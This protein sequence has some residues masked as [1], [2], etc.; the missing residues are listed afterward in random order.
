MTLAHFFLSCYERVFRLSTLFSHFS[1]LVLY[2]V[3]PRFFGSCETLLSL[4][5]SPPRKALSASPTLHLGLHLFLSWSLLF[6]LH[7]AALTLLILASL[8]SLPSHDLVI[9]T[10]GLVPFSFGE[11]GFG[12]LVNCLLCAAEVF[13][14]CLADPAC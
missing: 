8:D 7:T 10:D 5:L 4:M 2:E 13:L 11:E 3:K 6:L 12:V 14:S 1:S 9:W